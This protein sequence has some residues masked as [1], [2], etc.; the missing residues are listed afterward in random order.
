MFEWLRRRRLSD[1]AQQRLVM[2]LARSEEMLIETHVENV[3]EILAA[4]GEELPLDRALDVYLE[5][6]DPGEVRSALIVR[7]VLARISWSEDDSHTPEIDLIDEEDD[8][9]PA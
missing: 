9:E 4:V 6:M 3:F 7:R 2:T 5:A 8:D 1:R